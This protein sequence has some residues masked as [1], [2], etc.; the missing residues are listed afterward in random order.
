MRGPLRVQLRRSKG[1]RMPPN[2]VKVTRP[3]KYGNPFKAAPGMNAAAVSLFLQNIAA[4]PGD[5]LSE[6]ISVLRG[7]NLACWCRLCPDH[8]L[9]KPYGAACGKCAPCH[10]DIW[11][12]VANG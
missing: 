8:A 4:M 2:T 9:G 3:G 10:A 5:E 12:A 1:W 7:K 6:A 11:L